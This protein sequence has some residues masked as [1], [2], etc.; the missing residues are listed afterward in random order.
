MN[1]TTAGTKSGQISF[2]SNDNDESTFNFAISGTVAPA[3][4]PTEIMVLGNGRSITD[5][6]TSPSTTDGTS[7]GDAAFGSAGVRPASHLRS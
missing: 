1:A 4:T 2:T 6:D 5:G 7:F 3:P